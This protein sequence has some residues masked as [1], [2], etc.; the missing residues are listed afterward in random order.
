MSM[1]SVLPKT[2]REARIARG[3][4]TQ[5]AAVAK[6]SE[7]DEKGEGISAR[8]WSRIEASKKPSVQVRRSTA[9][10]IAKTLGLRVEDLGKAREA[11]AN[12]TMQEAG[13]QRIALWR[14][15]RV[16]RNYRWV[17]YHYDVSDQDLVDAAPWMF[18]LLAEMSLADRRSR[19]AA[20]SDAFDQAME[21]LPNH[22]Q[23]GRAA[24][25]DV[26]RAYFDEEDSISHRDIF[27]ARVLDT[28]D[29]GP[30]PFDPDVTN[31]FVEFLKN[32]AKERGSEE[33]DPENLDLPYGRGIPHWP[34]FE[35]WLNHLTGG[36]RWARFAVEN[37]K[38]VVQE[39]PEDRK[40]KERTAERVEW[41]VG[42]IPPEMRARE[43]ER[44]AE[45][46]VMFEK[47]RITL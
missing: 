43:E 33:I 37:I 27:G 20:W 8:Q 16:R 36:D 38:G 11:D 14:S 19:L 25:V 23:H 39:I 47:L 30:R 15:D 32:L 10:L 29:V 35:S 6:T 28:E 44:Q 45:A 12:K 26:E 46:T 9:E 5:E 2:L 13:Y 21:R 24:I 34:V 1:M 42:R 22:L 4:R 3:Y 31:P 40:G 17:T 7:V 18:T 41:L